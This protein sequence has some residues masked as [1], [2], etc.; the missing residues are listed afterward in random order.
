VPKQDLSFSK[1]LLN[2]AGSLGFAPDLHAPV[3]WNSFGGFVTNPISMR[4]RVAAHDPALIEYPGG[5]LI[6]SGLPNPGFRTLHSQYSWSWKRSPLPIVVSLMADRPEEAR[7]M[8]LALERQENMLAVE[9]SFA[10]LLADDLILLTVEM[11]IG[12]VPIIVSL[13]PDQVLRLG[14]QV[15]ARG[16][17]AISVGAP[18]GAFVRNGKLV[19]GRLFG[20][21]LLPLSLELV[22][23]ACKVG[24]TLIAAG[25]VISP[26]N[27]EAMLSAGALAVLL[28]IGLWHPSGKEKNPVR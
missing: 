14:A 10:P 5:V 28:D 1:P 27:I 2:A 23:S 25:G 20:P 24:L 26:L 17:A 3:E 21:S 13:P 16:A 18:R 12:E 15:E 11:C 6:H 4:P 22:R 9:L 8:V 19:S 7:E